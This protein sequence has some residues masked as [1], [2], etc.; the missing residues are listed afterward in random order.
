MA[1]SSPA[2]PPGPVWWLFLRKFFQQGTAVGAVTPSSRFLSRALLDD[3]D[4]R[5]GPTIVE[6]GA[7]TGAL[8]ADLL[9]RNAQGRSL[10][11]ERD[12]DFCAVLRGRFPSALVIEADAR[13]LGALLAQ[14]GVERVDHVLCGLAL[15]WFTPTDRHA[16]LETVRDHIAPEGSFRQLTYMPWVHTREYAR[17]FARVRFCFV[18][19][20]LPPGGF[21]I[22]TSPRIP[23]SRS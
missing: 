22:C 5:R 13:D 12:P 7:G 2:P 15:P 9:A 20:N 1:V 11:I 21:Y 18:F 6:L 8:T 23:L 14:H 17:Y 10:I 4:F 3:L 19:R 16:L